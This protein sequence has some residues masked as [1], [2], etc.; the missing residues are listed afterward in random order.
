MAFG[1]F[2]WFCHPH[3]DPEALGKRVPHPYMGIQRGLMQMDGDPSG[4]PHS[5]ALSS[6]RGPIPLGAAPPQPHPRRC[7]RKQ[8]VLEPPFKAASSLGATS[9]L[10]SPPPRST[11]CPRTC[12]EALR[13]HRPPVCPAQ[14]CPSSGTL[15]GVNKHFLQFFPLAAPSFS[16]RPPTLVQGA[17]SIAKRAGTGPMG[18]I[19]QRGV[20][21]LSV[22]STAP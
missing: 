20:P 2:V 21:A 1:T 8:V 19:A 5:G 6:S 9:G 3:Q 13:P 7:P 17:G 14:P 10:A 11:G 22:G 18:A 16:C 12:C 15:R 4:C